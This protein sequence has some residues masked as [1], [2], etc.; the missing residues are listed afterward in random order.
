MAHATPEALPVPFIVGSA[1][2]GTTLLRAMLEAGPDLAIPGESHFIPRF[3]ARRGRYERRTGFDVTAFCADLA[4]HRYFAA[5]GIPTDELSEQL[6][7]A[8]PRSVEAAIRTTFLTYAR[9]SGRT[10]WGDKTPAYVLQMPTIARMFPEAR[11]VHLI[12]DGR[13]VARSLVDLGWAS[14]IE[15]AA[16]RWSF[17]VQR[18]MHMGRELGPARYREVRYEALIDDPQ[19]VLADLCTSLQ[20]RFDE[21][22]IRP[23]ERAST[24]LGTVTGPENH[25]R[26]RLPPTKVRDWR[27]DMTEGEIARVEA[28]AGEI[29]TR[30]GYRRALPA[31]S[32]PT[33]LGVAA[34]RTASLPSRL[35]GR[36]RR[37]TW[38]G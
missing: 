26:L 36:V 19:P 18:G 5:W 13:D 28:V 22:M 2:S 29:L 9:R 12:R 31:P 15:D 7:A 21:R 34:R 6:R 35:T 24:L 1:R 32:L 27:T 25:Q 30:A 20:L 16:L 37:M 11:F 8:A 33:R 17:R 10:R 4:K 38:V 23:Q 3:R 14:T